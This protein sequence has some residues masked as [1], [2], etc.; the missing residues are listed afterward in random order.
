MVKF[1]LALRGN[2]GKSTV[3]SAKGPGRNTQRKL[4]Y[5]KEVNVTKKTVSTVGLLT[6]QSSNRCYTRFGCI[7]WM[8]KYILKRKDTFAITASKCVQNVRW[9]NLQSM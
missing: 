2:Y 8:H 6:K 1:W 5:R 4:E 7:I 3:T 9:F